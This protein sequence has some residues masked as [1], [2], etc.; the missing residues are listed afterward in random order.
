MDYRYIEVHTVY[1]YQQILMQHS[2][3]RLNLSEAILLFYR[4]P[5][6]HYQVPLH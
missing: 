4:L 5:V 2:S 6:L 1:L 3:H